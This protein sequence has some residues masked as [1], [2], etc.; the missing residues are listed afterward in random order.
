MATE[1]RN[2]T[3]KPGRHKRQPYIRKG[4]GEGKGESMGKTDAKERGELR[5]GEKDGRGAGGGG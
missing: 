5:I 2:V 1:G 4:K 3:S